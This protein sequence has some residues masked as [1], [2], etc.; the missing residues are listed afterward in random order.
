[1]RMHQES[2]GQLERQ[3]IQDEITCEQAK[4]ELYQLLAT[5][6]SVK[7]TGAAIAEAKAKADAAKI[8]GESEVR[9][10]ELAMKSVSVEEETE[11]LLSK[12]EADAEIAHKEELDKLEVE[13]QK[14]MA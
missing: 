13:Y 12:Q 9:T 11:L 5:N 2:F 4:R 7:T 14:Q 6:A 8:Q 1:M 10:S 3:K